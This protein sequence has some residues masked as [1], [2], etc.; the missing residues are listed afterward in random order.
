MA[1]ES[2][3]FGELMQRVQEHS[4]GAIQQLLE[5][6]GRHILRI[7]RRHLN[8]KVRAKFD[9]ADFVQAV[10][11]SFF[12]RPLN[13]DKF[14]QSGA[15][16]VFLAEMAQH[17]VVDMVRQ[18]L[19]TQKYDINRERPLETLPHGAD[20]LVSSAPTPEA[21]AIAREEW[22]KYV[23]NFPT[24]QQPVV[25]S[26]GAGYSAREIAAKTGVTER[27][28]HRIIKRVRTRGRP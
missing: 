10:W 19:H 18:R 22:A 1:G 16:G 7:V 6:Y 3:E 25:K 28:V 23:A 11:A 26:F 14:P 24:E 20:A 13:Q 4:Q 5:R 2:N 9:S 15:L 27:T 17:K 8:Q 21:M 12:A